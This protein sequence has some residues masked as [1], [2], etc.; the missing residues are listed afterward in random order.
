MSSK[1]YQKSIQFPFFTF[2]K[3]RFDA[4]DFINREKS[5]NFPHPV[6]LKYRSIQNWTLDQIKITLFF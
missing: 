1:N 2:K 4:N 3:V 6:A 5:N